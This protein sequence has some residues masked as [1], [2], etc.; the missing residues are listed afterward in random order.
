VTGAVHAKRVDLATLTRE[1][2]QVS[3]AR[4]AKQALEQLSALEVVLRVRL[5]GQSTGEVRTAALCFI[6]LAKLSFAQIPTQKQLYQ[7]EYHRQE[8]KHAMDAALKMLSMPEGWVFSPRYSLYERGQTAQ[9]A[10]RSSR[11]VGGTGAP[12]RGGRKSYHKSI[13]LKQRTVMK[14]RKLAFGE[15]LESEAKY[16]AVLRTLV[17]V[18]K[19][20]LRATCS[21]S[22]VAPAAT[23]TSNDTDEGGLVI[24]EAEIEAIF[25]NVEAILG[26]TS[27]LHDALSMLDSGKSRKGVGEIFIDHAPMMKLYMQ[28][29]NNFDRS[30]QTLAECMKRP[31]FVAQLE[32]L[33][34]NTE[35]Q[36]A[37]D[38]GAYLIAPV[39]RLPRYELLLTALQRFTPEE[40]ADYATLGTAIGKIKSINDQVNEDKRRAEVR[41]YVVQL[42]QRLVG[43]P[44]NLALVQPQRLLLRE[45]PLESVGKKKR[46]AI[47]CFLFTD[48]LL[49]TKVRGQQYRFL[50]AYAV[51][52]AHL[53]MADA[54]D[55]GP[56]AMRVVIRRSIGA[57]SPS[58]ASLSEAQRP[59]T[60]LSLEQANAAVAA[61]GSGTIGGSSSSPTA[62][63][64]LSL[65]AP[66]FADTSGSPS[67]SVVWI[68]ATPEDKQAWLSC[69]FE[70][71]EITLSP[72]RGK[73]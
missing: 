42:K 25:S 43:T 20:P 70:A 12:L 64:N 54:P 33:Y 72:L 10:A 57:G 61:A 32:V 71:L 41:A 27:Q 52:D 48:L 59:G 17:T 15:I 23:S 31:A 44:A 65:R 51:G 2:E 47:Y 45:G 60:I 7:M 18:F 53:M 29:I 55:A 36:G 35:D 9:E 4:A 46:K 30:V 5:P 56:C 49:V 37:L 16:L 38:L 34:K 62:G 58:S 1:R 39:Q 19:K 66:S 50:E 28:Y 14:N 69:F 6:N 73:R 26:L 67:E 40:F 13:P 8:L 24:T 63:M 21:P 22:T 3:I 11:I 68:A